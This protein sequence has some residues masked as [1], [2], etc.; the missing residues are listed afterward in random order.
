MLFKPPKKKNTKEF[1]KYEDGKIVTMEVENPRK[2][3]TYID[4][5]Y[6]Q[7]EEERPL[8]NIKEVGKQKIKSHLT[9]NVAKKIGFLIVLILFLFALYDV[10][11]NFFGTVPEES[12][13]TTIVEDPI[14]EPLNPSLPKEP[15][16]HPSSEPQTTPQPNNPAPAEPS[17]V[18]ETT[19]PLAEA[20]K[21]ISTVNNAIVEESSLE[22]Q[23]IKNYAD[24][25]ANKVGTERQIEK[26]LKAKEDLYIYLSAH[27][28]LFESE[29]LSDL[30]EA[31]EKRLL[32]S[33]LF[34]QELDSGI[35][36]LIGREA[37][38]SM[39]EAFVP[40][41]EELRKRG[42]EAMLETLDHYNVP[43]EYN[44]VTQEIKYTF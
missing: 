6:T 2:P 3:D 27:K 12:P 15:T 9:L 38:L 14:S 41:D 21:V 28:P 1:M 40:K 11:K 43:H 37:M 36:Q 31:T 44:E 17:G 13:P 22:V 39:T 33:I 10:Y 19:H 32:S 23:Q 42:I 29:P 25:K 7:K 34:S 8:K 30:Y 16:T 35:E 5:S 18:D 26:S 24:R 4:E 20:F